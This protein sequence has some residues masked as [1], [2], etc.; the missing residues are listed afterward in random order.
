MH[1][2]AEGV[3]HM[4]MVNQFFD[5]LGLVDGDDACV[6]LVKNYVRTKLVCQK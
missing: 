6:V 1:R 5:H 4:T 3:D 2:R